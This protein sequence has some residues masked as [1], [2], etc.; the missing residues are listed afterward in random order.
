MRREEV[1]DAAEQEDEELAEPL[2]YSITSY[3]AD[4]SIKR[5]VKRLKKGEITLLG[6]QR[7][8]VWSR[9]QA[10]RFVESLLF[11]LPVP[12]IFLYRELASQRLIVVDGHQ[13][14]LSLL[15]FYKDEFRGREFSLKG[16]SE[17]LVG[18]KYATLCERDRR[19][20]NT[21]LIHATI[22]QELDSGGDKGSVFEVFERLNTTTFPL[23]KQEIR[24]CIYRGLFNKLLNELNRDNAWRM[25]YGPV[26]ERA[27]DKELIL[28]FFA[29]K[30]CEN[31]YSRPLKH[32][33]NR[34]MEENASAS[35]EWIEK[36]R[37]EFQNVTEV[38]A[39]WL[40]REVFRRGDA[41]L[42]F[43]VSDAI[44]VGLSRRL[45]DGPISTMGT[46]SSIAIELR[47]SG[48]FI[49]VTGRSSTD[50]SSVRGRI[51]QATRAF[52]MD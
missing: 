38:A 40:P 15:S 51:D 47:D 49:S 11:G 50:V 31:R 29:L 26:S 35:A 16:V 9:A 14:L 12:G 18:L 23:S 24:G 4:F 45:D 7:R 8:C 34:Y 10:S 44:L 2:R 17:S 52:K 27:R 13:R 30:H 19:T 46:L 3:G 28:R 21:S 36:R 43:A 6:L 37:V 1:I 5:L 33:L 48:E 39:K 22:F 42:N 41:E 20:L 25:I 32:F